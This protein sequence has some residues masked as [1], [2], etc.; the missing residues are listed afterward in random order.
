MSMLSTERE[1]FEKQLEV[2]FGGYPTFVTAPRKE[3]YWRGLQ[4]MQLS[5][6]VRCVDAA[7][8]DQSEDGKKLPTVNRVWELSRALKARSL[9]TRTQETQAIYD[10]Y[11][12]LG[13]R[14]LFGFLLGKGGVDPD[15]LPK[16][17]AAKN[18][19]VSEFRECREIDTNVAEWLDIAMAE[20]ERVAA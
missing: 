20:F 10:D 12:L 1:D 2:L 18:L 3:A 11:H 5:M 9:P 4:K 15:K 8:Q 17:I 16:L 6:F 19:I 14:W 7:L 13:Q